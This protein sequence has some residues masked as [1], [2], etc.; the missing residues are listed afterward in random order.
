MPEF[1]NRMFGRAARSTSVIAA[2]VG[3]HEHVAVSGCSAAPPCGDRNV[4]IAANYFTELVPKLRAEGGLVE[5]DAV[6]LAAWRCLPAPQRRLLL[7]YE[8]RGLTSAQ[9]AS[10]MRRPE[11]QVRQALVRAI[12]QLTN[13]LESIEASADKPC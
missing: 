3:R 12:V 5:I 6:V 2:L 7:L 13:E 1:W 9:L 11:A 4:E 10:R 8:G